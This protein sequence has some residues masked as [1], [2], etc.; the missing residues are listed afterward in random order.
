NLRAMAT[1]V[2]HPTLSSPLTAGND[3]SSPRI[4]RPPVRINAEDVVAICSARPPNQL[5]V[6]SR[7]RPKYGVSAPSQPDFQVPS[8]RIRYVPVAAVVGMVHCTVLREQANVGGQKSRAHV[9]VVSQ[10]QS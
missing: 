6:N 8:W 1:L 4:M 10:F 3:I 5:T 2:W 9:Y 7:E